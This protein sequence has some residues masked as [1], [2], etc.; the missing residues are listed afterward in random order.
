[1]KKIRKRLARGS[2][3]QFTLS[4]IYCF[5][6]IG[7]Y[8]VLLVIMIVLFRF[9]STARQLGSTADGVGMEIALSKTFE[10]FL[11]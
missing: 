2:Y 4:K 8:A 5:R 7:H 1:M 10:L 9:G 6:N 11:Q 3:A